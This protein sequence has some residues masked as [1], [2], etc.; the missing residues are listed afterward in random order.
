MPNDEFGICVCFNTASHLFPKRKKPVMMVTEV[1]MSPFCMYVYVCV[2][3]WLYENDFNSSLDPCIG[4]LT[5]MVGF[6]VSGNKLEGELPQSFSKLTAMQYFGVQNNGIHGNTDDI[7]SKWPIVH[8]LY[9]DRN[10]FTGDF[11]TSFCNLLHLKVLSIESNHYGGILPVCIGELVNLHVV[12]IAR[13]DFYGGLPHSLSNLTLIELLDMSHNQIKDARYV[14]EMEGFFDYVS[15]SH[16]EIEYFPWEMIT[17]RSDA[18]AVHVLDIS[19]NNITEP[20]PPNTLMTYTA[21]LDVSTNPIGGEFPFLYDCQKMDKGHNLVHLDVSYTNIGMPLKA[22]RACDVRSLVFLYASH[23]LMSG[24][25]LSLICDSFPGI[26]VLDLTNNSLEGDIAALRVLYSL[27]SV[28]LKGNPLMRSSEKIAGSDLFEPSNVLHH[29]PEEPYQCYNVR[30]KE[31]AFTM[32]VD[33]SC[34]LYELCFCDPAYYGTP[35]NCHPC[36]LTAV[37]PGMISTTNDPGIIRQ[38]SGMMFATVGY[39]ASPPYTPIEQSSGMYPSHFLPCPGNGDDIT[40]RPHLS[41]YEKTCEDGY[42]DRLCSRCKSGYFASSLGCTKCPTDAI[43]WVILSGIVL[44]LLAILVTAFLFGEESS[45]FLK[46]LVFFVQ[47]MA[48]ID[49]PM[50]NVVQRIMRANGELSNIR[51]IGPECFVDGWEYIDHYY[52]N[53]AMPLLSCAVILLIYL[54]GILF[55]AKRGSNREWRVKCFRALIFL[56]YI[57]YMGTTSEIMRPLACEEDPGLHERFLVSVQYQK[58]ES[59]IQFISIVA[60]LVYVIGLPIVGAYLARRH[61]K[62][63]VYTLLHLS[64]RTKFKYWEFIITVRRI[65]FSISVMLIGIRSMFVV[66]YTMS[67]FLGTVVIQALCNPYHTRQENTMEIITLVVA[68]ITFSVSME[69]S[70]PE[71]RGIEGTKWCISI[72]YV[73]TLTYLIV[74]FLKNSRVGKWVGKRLTR[75]MKRSTM[76]GSDSV[77]MDS[78]MEQKLIDSAE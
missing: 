47:I 42:T 23:S 37:C 35:P 75:G 73:V 58:C 11:E 52:L 53:L 49:F 56:I 14:N 44:V 46:I 76:Y 63:R 68:A 45:G 71:V 70:V 18:E 40:C 19:N 2:C 55:A 54:V 34:F 1:S 60:L 29:S 3:R 4:D 51:F 6:E 24:D 65:L 16:N 33:D 39:W 15:F 43:K 36:P 26:Q 38:T 62:T 20:L 9:L 41:N 7:V 21:F 66:L 25:T 12:D 67:L 8:H 57:G 74:S 61:R 69:S 72:V 59:S 77:E 5:S 13:N 50:V 32:D 64:Y 28:L 27:S 48:G 17:A 30:G 31:D 78:V 22:R 10:N